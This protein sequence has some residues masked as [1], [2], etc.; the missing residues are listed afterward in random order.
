MFIYDEV[1]LS[2]AIKI[3]ALH[4]TPLEPLSHAQGMH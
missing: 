3:M 1:W 2:L 4:P